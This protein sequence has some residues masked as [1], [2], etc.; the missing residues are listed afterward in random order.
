MRFGTPAVLLVAVVALA[1]CGGSSGGGNDAF[2]PVTSEI[3]GLEAPA[4]ETKLRDLARG[5]GDKLVLYTSLVEKSE[6]AVAAAFE[7]RYGI[8]VSVFR[9]ESEP[10]SQRV[11]AE[12]KADRKG[13]DVVETS[14]HDLVTL[15]RLGAFVPYTPAAAS[16]LVPGS[17]HRG[18][19]ATRY[20]KFVVTWNTDRVK[21]DEVPRSIEDLA[22]PRW[23]DR[24]ALEGSDG[25][26]YKTLRDYWVGPGGKSEQEADR[27][28]RS[29]AHNARVGPSHGAISDLLAAGEF[30]VTPT[31][32]LHQSRDSVAEHAP[33]A[34][35]PLVGPVVSRP[36]GVALLKTSAH[37]AAAVLFVEW[38][39]G[40]DGQRVLEDN[41]VEV[42]RRGMATPLGVKQLP[43]D[44]EGFADVAREWND[45]YDALLRGSEHAGGG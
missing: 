10:V 13:T 17:Q 23:H 29:I 33:V 43:V 28:F 42:A 15:D 40:E 30:D 35:E 26:W 27:L 37:P 22:A 6:K 14:G 7:K 3:K 1:G 19:T 34:Y 38:L 4:R 11:S 8:K 18:W 12:V 16:G 31:N 41:N 45:R 9:S 32:Y 5:E 25:D 36:N 44:V 20:N 39:L 24:V 2:E 21:G